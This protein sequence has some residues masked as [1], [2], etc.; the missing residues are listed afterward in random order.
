MRCA[1]CSNSAFYRIG[2]GKGETALCLSCLSIYE[3][4]QFREWLKS[5]AMMNHASESMDAMLGGLG[6]PSPRIPVEAIARTA[7]MATTYNNIS[8]SNSNVGVVNTDNLAR[9]DAAITMS[10][11]TETEEFGARLKDL[12]EAVLSDA[13]ISRDL[14]QQMIE[15]TQAISD[16]AI[17]S[18][19]PSAIVVSTLFGQ[20]KQLAGDVTIIAGAAEKLHEAWTHLQ[21]AL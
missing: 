4:I 8:I 2:N 11:G 6:G 15:V 21:A 1:Q 9:I 19:K 14:K 12:T 3:G 20:L 5:A 17:G 18:K 10:Q 16:Q 13:A 7:S